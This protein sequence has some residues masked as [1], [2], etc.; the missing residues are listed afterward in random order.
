MRSTLFYVPHT[1]LGFPVFGFG[2]LLIIW[3]ILSVAIL[4]QSVRRHGWTRDLTGHLTLAIL[5]AV[6]IAVVLPNLAEREGLPI[7]GYGTMLLVATVAA[8][9]L[10]LW[11][12][13]RHGFD[14]EFIL[15]LTVWV[16]IAGIAG[17]R[18]FYVVEYWHRIRVLDQSGHL[19]FLPT[20]VNIVNL[21]QG[22]LVVY[23]SICGGIIAIVL[24]T[25]VRRIPLLR[26]MDFIAPSFMLGLALG[27]LGCFL[28]GCCY[29]AVCDLPW[30][31]RFPPG[32]LPHLHQVEKGLVYLH[33]LKLASSDPPRVEAVE[34]GSPAEGAGVR[35]GDRILAA[36][37]FPTSTRAEAISALFGG[38]SV[39]DEICLSIEGRPGPVCFEKTRLQSLPVHPTQIY[40]AINAFLICLFLLAVERVRRF[41]GQVVATMF[42]V[43]PL[44]RFLIEILRDDEPWIVTAGGFGLTIAQTISLLLLLGVIGLWGYLI[45]RRPG[46]R[47]GV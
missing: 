14:S 21:A 3:L 2:W 33:G 17:A 25:R 1:F 5:V 10:A 39:A 36:G 11:R 42:T 20:L 45:V 47:S 15:S 30:A 29:G 28:N 37:S 34:P 22:G 9:A 35:P 44:T 19:A 46:H 18:L 41:D 26:T 27:R 38:D 16:F 7:R 4:V 40:S 12:A 31:V 32:S 24:L 6:F 43:Y 23:G 8:V 13:P